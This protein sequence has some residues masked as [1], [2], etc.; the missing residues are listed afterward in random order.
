MDIEVQRMASEYFLKGQL[1][2]PSSSSLPVPLHRIL[3]LLAL[4]PRR[5]LKF[6]FSPPPPAADGVLRLPVND[7]ILKMPGRFL[8]A[9]LKRLLTRLGVAAKTLPGLFIRALCPRDLV[10]KIAKR[11]AD[12]VRD[13]VE[14]K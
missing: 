7:S 12:D 8:F 1:P 11:R 4:L 10:C 14:K 2:T 13:V 6:A 9:R 5:L 3:V